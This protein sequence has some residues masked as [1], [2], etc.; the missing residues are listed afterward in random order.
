MVGRGVAETKPELR[1][2]VKLKINGIGP[3]F[4]GDYTVTDVAIRFDTKAGLRT[5]FMCER[6]SI[7]SA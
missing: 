3:L 1:V 5:E 2:G 4:E 6:P 7:G